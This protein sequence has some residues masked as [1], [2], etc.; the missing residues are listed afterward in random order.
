VPDKLPPAAT[1]LSGGPKRMDQEMAA[2]RVTD[3]Q[4]ARS[5]EPQF[6]AALKGKQAAQTESTAGQTRMRGHENATIAGVR[7][8]LVPFRDDMV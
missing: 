7:E 1:D 8:H 6:T 5:N 3:A 4:L 2:A